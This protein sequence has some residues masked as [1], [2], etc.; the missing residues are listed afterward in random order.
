MSCEN[1][2]RELLLETSFL[3]LLILEEFA[4]QLIHFGPHIICLFDMFP[5]QYLFVFCFQ[6]VVVVAVV[7]H[8]VVQLGSMNKVGQFL[9]LHSHFH[10]L[11]LRHA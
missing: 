2:K 5:E 8:G 4:L 1:Y 3:K 7:P 9:L 11:Y 6:T 10:S